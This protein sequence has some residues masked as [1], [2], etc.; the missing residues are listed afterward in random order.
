[1]GNGIPRLLRWLAVFGMGLAF[2]NFALAFA[3]WAAP[4]RSKQWVGLRFKNLVSPSSAPV[5]RP[6]TNP[7]PGPTLTAGRLTE[8]AR[9]ELGALFQSVREPSVWFCLTGI[10]Y[11]FADRQLTA[12]RE[13]DG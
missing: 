2:V 4:P 12:R 9:T 8:F 6:A 5:V 1:M 11:L 13:A 3:G 7:A 10:L